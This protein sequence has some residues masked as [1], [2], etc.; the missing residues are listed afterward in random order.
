MK[1]VD[2]FVS[3]LSYEAPNL[4]DNVIVAK[5]KQSRQSKYYVWLSKNYQEQKLLA[6]S[7]DISNSWNYIDMTT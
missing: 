6:F 7:L 3:N 1:K 5:F 4:D 2:I